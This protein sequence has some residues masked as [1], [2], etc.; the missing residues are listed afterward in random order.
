[1]ELALFIIL[2]ISS[3]D[4]FQRSKY[5]A[6]HYLAI[7]FTSLHFV[8]RECARKLESVDSMNLNAEKTRAGTYGGNKL[9]AINFSHSYH[10]VRLT[11]SKA[12][13]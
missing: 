8:A 1:M 4:V 6:Y 12:M 3:N 5:F 10:A 2:L 13:Q 9:V 11:V 7:A